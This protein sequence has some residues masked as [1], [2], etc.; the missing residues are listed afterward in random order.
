MTHR[1]VLP[2]RA[3]YGGSPINADY[4]IVQHLRSF[5]AQHVK[6]LVQTGDVVVDIGCG[7]QPLRSLVESRGGRYFG[8]DI[9]QNDA[10]TVCTIAA[11]THAPF[12]DHSFDLV[13]C[14]EVLEHLPEAH[15]SVKEL[16]RLLKP[17]GHLILT[18]PFLYPLHEEPHDYLRMTDH[19][20]Q[21]LATSNGLEVLRVGRCGNELEVMATVWCS[22]WV[23]PSGASAEPRH[24][25]LFVLNALSRLGANLLAIL[26]NR[27][28]GSFMPQRA[29][30]STVCVLRR[31]LML[32]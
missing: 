28:V 18:V 20:A 3:E 15:S 7:G 4:F 22:L 26:G 13:L 31:P 14:T 23:R 19:L 10:G 21:L 27:L 30:L 6:E 17:G 8:V 2:R 25:F 1:P 11:A 29:Y 12:A 9:S 24:R 32:G 16:A 5:L